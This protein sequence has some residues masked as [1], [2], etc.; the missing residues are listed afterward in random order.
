MRSGWVYIMTNRPN[1]TLYTGVAADEAQ[2][3]S[4]MLCDN[5][6]GVLACLLSPDSGLTSGWS[7]EAR[8]RHVFS[9][10][11]MLNG[12]AKAERVAFSWIR[13]VSR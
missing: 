4:T 11:T 2:K 3:K 5:Q 7:G 12:R 10:D 1:G 9:F 13:D 6:K 8:V